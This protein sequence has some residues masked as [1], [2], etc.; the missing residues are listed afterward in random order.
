[1]TIIS[2]RLSADAQKPVVE[3]LQY[4]HV[5]RKLT[6]PI[7]LQARLDANQGTLTVLESAV[8]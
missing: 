5:S 4:G 8:E 7:G 2:T 1:M 6:L 3:G